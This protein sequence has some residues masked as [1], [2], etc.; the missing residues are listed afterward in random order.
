VEHASGKG[1]V[2]KLGEGVHVSLLRDEFHGTLELRAVSTVSSDIWFPK[3]Q[4][5]GNGFTY[6]GDHLERGCECEEQTWFRGR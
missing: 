2:K 6:I 1:T 5:P 3:F 4:T